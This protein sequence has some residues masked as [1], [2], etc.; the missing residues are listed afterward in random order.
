M[1]LNHAGE[2]YPQ[3]I[4]NSV[5]SIQAFRLLL[6]LQVSGYGSVIGFV[7]VCFPRPAGW[8]YSHNPLSVK[9]LCSFKL[10]QIGFVLHFSFL[11]F[12]CAFCL[13]RI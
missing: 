11:L 7:W 5:L 6:E 2:L 12:P 8:T 1:L 13:F 4:T 9:H 10:L 3:D